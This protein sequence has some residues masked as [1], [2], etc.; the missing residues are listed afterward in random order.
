MVFLSLDYFEEEDSAV[1]SIF[2]EDDGIL[3]S[4]VLNYSP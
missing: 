3:F 2:P 4:M 1:A